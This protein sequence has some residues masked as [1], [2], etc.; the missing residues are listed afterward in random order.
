MSVIVICMCKKQKPT[1]R[2][3]SSNQEKR[4]RRKQ[5]AHLMIAK[6]SKTFEVPNSRMCRRAMGIIDIN[7][8]YHTIWDDM[9]PYLTNE[10]NWPSNPLRQHHLRP[11]KKRSI[12]ITKANPAKRPVKTTAKP[13]DFPKSI[14]IWAPLFGVD[15]ED[16]PPNPVY[17]T[18]LVLEAPDVP[19]ALWVVLEVVLIRVGFWAPHGLSSRHAAW[20]VLSPLHALTQ[21]VAYW[22]QM[23]YG[24]VKE[25]SDAFG[26]RPLPQMHA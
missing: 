23:K 26:E 6:V 15:V 10:T 13:Y 9:K 1:R 2:S 19:V 7:I 5:N 8:K 14:V 18:P 12:Y 11:W 24:R 22:V 4:G 25:Y 21:L 20:Q 16:D 3:K 17:A